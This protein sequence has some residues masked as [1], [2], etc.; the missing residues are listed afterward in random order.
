VHIPGGE[1]QYKST[2]HFPVLLPVNWY[3]TLEESTSM[4]MYLTLP[5]TSGDYCKE[6]WSCRFFASSFPSELL[7]QKRK[8]WTEQHVDWHGVSCSYL[9]P[10]LFVWL[11]RPYV[12]FKL[13]TYLVLRSLELSVRRWADIREECPP[14]C[15][16]HITEIVL[17]KLS[18]VFMACLSP[19]VIFIM[20]V[21]LF[22]IGAV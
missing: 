7:S 6:T 1:R 22:Q 16:L 17:L 4:H 13:L 20:S 3:K 18:L 15:P 5:Y 10:A 9:N 8:N 21:V 12:T 14:V 11:S 2:A 19:F